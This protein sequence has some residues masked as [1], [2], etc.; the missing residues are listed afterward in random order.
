MCFDFQKLYDGWNAECKAWYES[1]PDDLKELIKKYPPDICYKIKDTRGH[2]E[3][4][5]YEELKDGTYTVKVLHLPGSW[6]FSVDGGQRIMVF[7]IKIDTLIPCN[8]KK[9]EEIWEQNSK[10]E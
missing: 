1:R 10:A 6:G 5:S 4:Y 3:L 7:G 2:Y 9:M 8:C